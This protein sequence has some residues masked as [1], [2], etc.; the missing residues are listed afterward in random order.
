LAWKESKP[1]RAIYCFSLAATLWSFCFFGSAFAQEQTQRRQVTREDIDTLSIDAWKSFAWPNGTAPAIVHKQIT[2]D[3]HLW[4]IPPFVS[5]SEQAT[6]YGSGLCRRVS[7]H[8]SLQWKDFESFGEKPDGTWRSP[9]KDTPVEVTRTP[10]QIVEYAVAPYCHLSEQQQFFAGGGSL[11]GVAAQIAEALVTA[12]NQA[13]R[14]TRRLPYELICTVERGMDRCAGNARAAFASINLAHIWR[15]VPVENDANWLYW[16]GPY[17]ATWVIKM[18][19]GGERVEKIEV[20]ST[21]PHP[22]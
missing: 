15:A 1:N 10:S 13:K 20:T 2:P 21:I 16:I 19:I 14:K 22:Y 9:T 12:Q 11:D 5:L 3:R 17:G 8:V 18:K 4:L 7:Y 6:P